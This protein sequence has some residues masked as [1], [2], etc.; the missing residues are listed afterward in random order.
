VLFDPIRRRNRK[1]D[2]A[3]RMQKEKE[4]HLGAR[5]IKILFLFFLSEVLNQY[6]YQNQNIFFS[7]FLK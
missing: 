3:Y 6:I 7:T 5:S 4:T 1:P 2:F